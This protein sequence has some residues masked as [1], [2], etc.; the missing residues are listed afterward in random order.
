[1]RDERMDEEIRQHLD[2]G[3]HREAFELL[4]DRYQ[5]KVFHLALSLMRDRQL[6]EDMA[7]EAFMRIWKGLAGYRG[8][9]SLSTWIY[10]VARNTCLSELK[11]R[12]SRPRLVMEESA[13]DHAV[14]APAAGPDSESALD[15]KV[16]LDRLPERYRQ[17]LTL[18]YLEERS[19]QE[20][21]DMLG[22]PTGTVKTFLHRAKKE[23]VELS[24][25]G[26]VG[27]A[28]YAGKGGVYGV[29]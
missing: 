20:V 18:Y 23:L 10:A 21:A 16:L 5:D 14:E 15:V 9:A 1:L 17:A 3:R 25:L 29:S 12:A 22:V 19:Y 8:A 11:R 26:E 24:S 28:R 2:A 13:L 4:V 7:Q 6:A 27:R